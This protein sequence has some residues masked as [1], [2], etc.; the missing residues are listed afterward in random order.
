MLEDGLRFPKKPKF[1]RY[2]KEEL[3]GVV[4]E[5]CCKKTDNRML[6]LKIESLSAILCILFTMEQM[7]EHAKY[8]YAYGE[9]KR[10]FGPIK[11]A[12]G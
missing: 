11:K 9:G 6:G 1:L 3:E 12:F 8:L 7:R 10:I 2:T 5:S 4:W